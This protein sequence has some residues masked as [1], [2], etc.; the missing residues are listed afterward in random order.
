MT[1]KNIVT[2]TFLLISFL[3]PALSFAQ[4]ERERAVTKRPVDDIFWSPNLVTQATVKNLSKGMLNVNIKH[5]FGFIDDGANDLFGLDEQVNVRLGVDY[6][7]TD[8]ISVG[9]GRQSDAKVFDLRTKINI[10]EQM[11]DDSVPLFIAWKGSVARTTAENNLD[12]EDDLSYFTSVMF[13]RKFGDKLSLQVAPMFTHFNTV[14]RPREGDE[15]LDAENNH[16]AI[17]LGLSYKINKTFAINIDYLPVIGERTD[18]TDNTFSI[19]LDVETGGHVFQMFFASTRW[20]TED[21]AI[22]RNESQ[23][24]ENEIRFGFNINRVF[25]LGGN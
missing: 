18:N 5:A 7:I 6:G 9:F 22:A 11:S 20:H 14:I 1:T 4:M 19:G 8:K 12:F 23:F 13:A 2:V 21:Y 25:G 16:Y 24:F 10:I 3:L 17:G 15:L